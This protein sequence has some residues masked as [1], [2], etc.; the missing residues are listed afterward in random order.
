LAARRLAYRRER[1]R[2]EDRLIDVLIAAEALYLSPDARTEL[3]YRL[4]LNAAMFCNVESI[5]MDRNEVFEIMRNLYVPKLVGTG[6]P[7]GDV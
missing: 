5:S 1:H 3:S 6:I 7:V 2:I 4:A